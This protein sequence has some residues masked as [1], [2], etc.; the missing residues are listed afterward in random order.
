M[1]TYI[2]IYIYI[3]TFK[4]QQMGAVLVARTVAE[5]ENKADYWCYN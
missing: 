1:Y 3:Y 5:M 2:Y 4:D